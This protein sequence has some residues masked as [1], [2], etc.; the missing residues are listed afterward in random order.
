MGNRKI[1]KKNNLDKN[2]SLKATDIIESEDRKSIDYLPG[3]KKDQF[4]NMTEEELLKKDY[5]D[6]IEDLRDEKEAEKELAEIEDLLEYYLQ[7]TVTTQAEA[8]RSLQLA[9][10]LEE[11][12]SVNLSALR[13]EVNRLELTLAIGS[14]AVAS[15]ALIAGI[16]G[17]NLQSYIENSTGGFVAICSIIILTIFLI[18]YLLYR[19][20]KTKRIF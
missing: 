10:D 2:I 16:F 19:Q 3:V 1:L 20:I 15:G 18:G 13:F 4:S 8:E 11:S 9:R 12:I 14:F 7:R 17:M 6:A 5:E